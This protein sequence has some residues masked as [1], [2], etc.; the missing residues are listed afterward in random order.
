MKRQRLEGSNVLMFFISWYPTSEFCE[1]S[2][3]SAS[4][5]ITA[6]TQS[7]AALIEFARSPPSRKDVSR[8]RGANAARCTVHVALQ[9]VCC[10]AKSRCMLYARRRVVRASR[11]S[12]AQ[13]ELGPADC[14]GVLH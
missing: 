4:E 11:P 14:R 7:F 5:L 8:E 10:A 13:R 2:N 9:A 12:K 3:A 6:M 1:L